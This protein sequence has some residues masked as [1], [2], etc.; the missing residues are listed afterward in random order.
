MLRKLLRLIRDPSYESTVNFSFNNYQNA[1]QNCEMLQ[2]TVTV[3]PP[4]YFCLDSSFEVE[5]MISGVGHI[6]TMSSS[7]LQILVPIS[8]SSLAGATET[9][10]A[11]DARK[12]PLVCT[13]VIYE[14]DPVYLAHVRN[15]CANYQHRHFEVASLETLVN[16][17]DSLREDVS[18]VI[19]SPAVEDTFELMVREC[20]KRNVFVVATRQRGKT[21]DYFNCAYDGPPTEVVDISYILH[22]PITEESWTQFLDHLREVK[23]R[24]RMLQLPGIQECKLIR[25]VGSTN[26]SRVDL[27][28]DVLT[29]GV[30]ARKTVY[31]TAGRPLTSLTTEV[32]IMSRLR[33]HWGILRYIGSYTPNPREFCMFLQYCKG[34]TLGTYARR[35]PQKC[36]TVA[37]LRPYAS[38]LL[39]AMEFIHGNGVAH[40]DIKPA[41]ILLQD[42]QHLKVGDFGSATEQPQLAGHIAGGTLQ[43]MAPERLIE[44]NTEEFST[45]G[46]SMEKLYAEDIWSVGLTLLELLGAYPIA[47]KG[48][49]ELNSF[50]QVYIEL[51]NA[52]DELGFSIPSVPGDAIADLA[53]DFV[54][55]MLQMNPKKR[56]SAATLVKHPFVDGV[57]W[58]I[59]EFDGITAPAGTSHLS[60]DTPRRRDEYVGLGENSYSFTAA[61]GAEIDSDYEDF[62]I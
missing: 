6:Y 27:V 55:C 23:K 61:S 40:R 4:S 49:T 52:G 37:E 62:H 60:M 12:A 43:F 14:P 51:R 8:P 22:K 58:D 21:N 42:V 5:E 47:L 25:R 24:Q 28:R 36:L 18:A 7:E 26:H 10:R 48:L 2:I 45:P 20:L 3:A 57:T 35:R 32:E 19:L 38:Q 30:M 29:G 9:N 13:F 44:M 50:M 53:H 34:G 56:P 59:A 33:A 39:Y 1:S 17:L 54:R 16:M 46:D 11:T 41:N 15:F 31:I